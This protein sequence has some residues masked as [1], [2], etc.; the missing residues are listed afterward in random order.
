[1]SGRRQKGSETL[2]FDFGVFMPEPQPS[3]REDGL[4]SSV[5]AAPLKKEATSGDLEEDV[6]TPSL[7]PRLVPIGPA[8]ETASRPSDALAPEGSSREA[9][10]TAL[11]ASTPK[12]SRRSSSS[13]PSQIPPVP[14][15]LH[16][17][18]KSPSSPPAPDAEAKI[19]S[20]SSRPP[21]PNPQSRVD[22][23]AAPAS[24]T[25]LTVAQLGRVLTRSL[26]RTFSDALWVEG[27]VT[28]ARLA[29]S[30]HVYFALKDEEEDAVIDVV[31]YR[32]Q[33]T[34]RARGLVKDGVRIRLRGK[35]TFWSPRGKMQFIGD[36]IEPTGKGALLEAL[37]KLKA[38]LAAE[39]LFATEKKR[40]LPHDPRIVGV[41]TSAAGA[42]IHD[43]CK[44]AFRRGGAHILLAPAQVQGAGAAESVR[45]ALAALQRV[46]E[47]DVIILGRG[48]GSQDDLLAFHDEQL[49]R[50]VAAC[51]VPI[52]SAVGHETDITL[53]DFAAD[54]RA[55]TPSQ[56]AELVVPD[57][58]ARKRLLEERSH[59]L[60]RAMHAR[61]T[62]DRARTSRLASSFRD[63]RLLIASAQQR[64]DD[65]M[66]R[67][68]RVLTKRFARDRKAE[69]KLSA[70]LAAAHP[71]ARIARDEA[72]RLALSGR[73][74]ELLRARLDAAR[75]ARERH[76]VRLSDQMRTRMNKRHTEVAQLAGRLDAMSPLKVL[77][78]GYAIA[79]HAKDGRAVRDISEVALGDRVELR[80]CHG[81]F[82]AEV[83]RI[84]THP[85]E[86][87]K[88][89]S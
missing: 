33:V 55:S 23:S 17:Q 52:V 73:L 28:G 47:V 9:S 50:D 8:R 22:S 71:R 3:L 60:R 4:L 27:E 13:P 87:P 86:P 88:N 65:C 39:G 40:E 70:R 26:E 81:E 83:V 18:T 75:V 21:P 61:I 12:V 84:A 63:P 15:S 76:Q 20:S 32:A 14:A 68:T 89:D 1:M 62:N 46:S 85:L 74:G 35:P 80:V 64:V 34:P 29:P 79:T 82:E 25:V 48:G 7:S 66:A 43:I 77:S 38:K 58:Y 5:V 19:T 53:V 56:A 78:R 16:R 49:V 54:A 11:P 41:V 57:A 42:V 37:E 31:V 6:C 44:V 67:I 24:P 59:R 45:R 69:T 2:P 72:T 51:R 30:G 10:A 36:R